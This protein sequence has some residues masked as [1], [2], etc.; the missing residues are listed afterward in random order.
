VLA[1][2]GGT[3]TRLG[4]E[5]DDIGVE[6]WTDVGRA[7]ADIGGS[8][9]WAIGDW[10][11]FGEQREWGD[12]Y[13][14][15]LALFDLDYA[16]LK[17]CKWVAKSIELSRRS[18]QLS[19]GHHR[20]VAGLEPDDQDRWLERA[21]SNS[22]TAR[23]LRARLKG[24][25]PT[26]LPVH[27]PLLRFCQNLATPIIVSQILRVYFSDA[28]TALDTTGGDGGFWDGSEPVSVTQLIRDPLRDDGADFRDLDWDDDS[29]DVV[30]LD[31]PHLA[32]AGD[33]GIMGGRFGTYPD[34]HLEEVVR[35]GARE[36]WRV[37]RLG[38]VVKVTDH[39]HGQ[40]Y[41]LESDWVRNAIE[42]EPFDEV[43]QVRSGAMIDPK[44][45]QQLSAYNNGSTFLIFRK[46]GD[47][48]VRRNGALT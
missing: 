46:D 42:R 16:S 3:L 33:D 27:T 13:T 36:A 30:F 45:E 41:V 9:R 38:L 21:A 43:Y 48:H 39:V 40:R 37:C 23:E 22:W 44:W 8:L 11:L 7:L 2:D 29:V 18:R 34:G 10:L 24:D 25:K 1:F 20:E 28:E 26:P 4:L 14:D 12:K 6:R 17:D 5:L 47:R 35:D 19:W 32:D 15:A 31:P